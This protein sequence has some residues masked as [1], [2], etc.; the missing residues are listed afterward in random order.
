M[1]AEGGGALSDGAWDEEGVGCTSFNLSRWEATILRFNVR[2][3]VVVMIICCDSTILARLLAVVVSWLIILS[4][5]A[6]MVSKRAVRFFQQDS[7]VA[8]AL[9][10]A[11]ISAVNRTW[12]GELGY[13][14]WGEW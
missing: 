6:F 2:V 9:R 1:W 11:L 7:S 12:R 10:R 5:W 4:M 13:E 8:T 3:V 14:W